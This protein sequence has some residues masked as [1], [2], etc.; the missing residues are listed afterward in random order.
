MNYYKI[1]I[2]LCLKLLLFPFNIYAQ[3]IQTAAPSQELLWQAE[4]A[5]RAEYAKPIETRNFQKAKDLYL[6]SAEAG[7]PEAMYQ[8]GKLEISLKNIEIGNKWVEK[9]AQ[10]GSPRGALEYGYYAIIN[11]KNCEE[12]L[13]YYI[14]SAKY[15]APA[16]AA[17]GNYYFDGK[18]I[19]RDAHQSFIWF[20]KGATLGDGNSQLSLGRFYASSLIGNPDYIKAHAWLNI[21]SHHYTNQSFKN[22]A[23]ID[24]KTVEKAMQ[25]SD[26]EKAKKQASNICKKNIGACNNFGKD[27]K[28]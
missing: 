3:T 24:L 1:S 22:L 14:I 9:S 26:I 8:L 2:F 25:P 21:A 18:C 12:G 27:T 28:F 11:L 23:A 19:N 17:L 16:N 4:A 7:H 20:E 15:Y 6:K 13:K 10:N 5:E